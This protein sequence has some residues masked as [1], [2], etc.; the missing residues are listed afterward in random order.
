[1]NDLLIVDEN[2]NYINEIKSKLSDRFKIHD[3]KSAQHYLSIEIVRDGDSILFC[4][5][6]YLKKML[7]RFGMKNCKTVGSS[8]ESDLTAIMM[9]FNDEHQAH[10]DIIY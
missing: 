7:E 1:M 2:M 9:S 10:A 8:I 4:Q 3:L 5:I 6:N